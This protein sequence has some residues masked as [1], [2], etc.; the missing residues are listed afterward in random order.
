MGVPFSCLWTIL[1]F[2]TIEILV[3]ISKH[4]KSIIVFKRHTDEIFIIRIKQV[5]CNDS[6]HEL[7]R[8]LNNTSN[9]DWECEKPSDTVT[10]LDLDITI[11]RKS[12]RFEHKMHVKRS[13]SFM[14]ATKLSMSAK[15][16]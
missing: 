2:A 1:I 13:S 3:L 15:C 11:N 16:S 12:K 10:F 14:Q 6:F 4:K 9:L 8:T 7:K 5:E